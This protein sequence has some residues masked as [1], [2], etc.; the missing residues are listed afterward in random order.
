MLILRRGLGWMIESSAAALLIALFLRLHLGRLPVPDPGLLYQWGS[1]IKLTAFFMLGSWY[2]A[3]TAA[4]ALSP[5]RTIGV[6]AYPT[7]IAI[8]FFIHVQMFATGWSFGEQLPVQLV[9]GLI[10]FACALAG[11]V[12]L[13]GFSDAG[14]AG[15]RTG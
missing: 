15:E 10:V 3:T 14:D 5:L 9:G 4:A 6:W 1:Y 13:R 8:L 7:T 2:V 12:V 11:N